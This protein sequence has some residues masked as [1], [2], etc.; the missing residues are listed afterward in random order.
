VICLARNFQCWKIIFLFFYDEQK[1]K[2]QFLRST[3]Q[4]QIEWQ[5]DATKAGTALN[6]AA[7]LQLSQQS[8]TRER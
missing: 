3:K 8:C 7:C 1:K 6:I 4:N 5:Y 2:E